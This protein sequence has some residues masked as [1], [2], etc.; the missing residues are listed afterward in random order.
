MLGELI[1]VILYVED[2]KRQVKFYHEVLG[3]V[4]YLPVDPEK[5]ARAPWVE[6]E[7]GHCKLCLHKG[8]KGRLGED[9]GRL[10]FR[11]KDVAE[12]RE[13]L[14]EKGVNMG[15]I[16]SFDDGIEVADGFDPEGN[17]FSIEAREEV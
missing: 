6:F 7:T 3:L 11:V 8:G 15:E 9:A 14:M 16:Q 17:R 2:M 5:A 12:A 10:V 4:P 13:M 1:E